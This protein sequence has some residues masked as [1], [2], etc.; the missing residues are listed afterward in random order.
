MEP[1]VPGTGEVARV[2]TRARRGVS[3]VR[4]GYRGILSLGDPS[5]V[6]VGNIR[7]Y[8]V[9]PPESGYAT[10]EAKL[11]MGARVSPTRLS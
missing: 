6:S 4:A 9:H 8:Q 11:E 5:A 3:E 2:A 1:R 10:G 7:Q